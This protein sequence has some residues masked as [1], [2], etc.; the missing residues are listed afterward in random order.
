MVRGLGWMV[1]LAAMS[2]A[3]GGGALWCTE[4]A[5]AAACWL[6]GSGTATIV[7]LRYVW[8]H[9]T[10]NRP[11]PDAP[12][13]AT[14]GIANGVTLARGL[15]VAMMVGFFCPLVLGTEWARW[16]PG[17]LYT[18]VAVSDWWDGFLART[19]GQAS[20]LGAR[21]DLQ[22]DA[23]GVLLASGLAVALGRLPWW[24]LLVGLAR[25]IYLGVLALA[26]R[27]GRVPRPMQP[28]PMRRATAGLMMAFLAVSLW[29]FFPPAAL[30][31]VGLWFFLPF[32]AGF[33]QDLGYALVPHLQPTWLPTPSPLFLFGLRLL[34]AIGWVVGAFSALR[35]LPWLLFV[36]SL[37]AVGLALGVLPRM[38]ALLALLVWGVSWSLGAPIPHPWRDGVAA[39]L[40]AVAF[41]GGGRACLWALD[42]VVFLT[43]LGG[44]SLVA[45]DG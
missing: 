25:E 40:T 19:T 30:R 1:A 3:A 20:L 21:L 7:V 36:A 5:G 28:N 14:L 34:A 13:Y 39:L 12:P 8:H 4:G 16:M 41:W 26:R 9:R 10:E 33:V 17:L 6:L 27:L 24:Y 35:A 42:D 37:L 31:V 18:F 44:D 15:A 11:S 45:E 2:L 23:W 38:T 29:P 43:A 32:M 22:L